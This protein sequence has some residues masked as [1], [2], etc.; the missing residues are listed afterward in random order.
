MAKEKAKSSRRPLRR[1]K[2]TKKRTD[3]LNETTRRQNKPSKRRR[4]SGEHGKPKELQQFV[5]YD[6]PVSFV[7]EKYLND[8]NASED[9][10][11]VSGDAETKERTVT[12]EGKQGTY[13]FHE[14]V[15][16]FL[17][18]LKEKIESLSAIDFEIKELLGSLDGTDQQEEEDKSPVELDVYPARPHGR[19]EKL[20]FVAPCNVEVIGRYMLQNVHALPNF[21]PGSVSKAGSSHRMLPE[22]DLSFQIPSS[23]FETRDYLNYRY[24]NRKLLYVRALQRR[25][26]HAGSKQVCMKHLRGDKYRPMLCLEERFTIEAREGSVGLPVKFNLI[27]TIS[28][29]VFPFRRFSLKQNNVRPPVNHDE[30]D[31]SGDQVLSPTP[32]YNHQL[33]E[34]VCPTNGG[35]R[36]SDDKRTGPAPCFGHFYVLRLFY[37][38]Q[39]QLTSFNQTCLLIDRFL[40]NYQLLCAEQKCLGFDSFEMKLLLAYFLTEKKLLVGNTASGFHVFVLLLSHFVSSDLSRTVLRLSPLKDA[41]SDASG[42]PTSLLL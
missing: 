20:S 26:V 18:D 25:L 10:L 4:K 31:V 16:R 19:F 37:T 15:K 12:V 3:R 38:L 27:P 17:F 1:E 9:L 14:Q 24:F 40:E 41:R 42:M 39:Q 11:V 36:E 13:S 22:I 7:M 21:L 29:S 28:L 30:E 35:V 34:D 2:A 6:T 23:I 8:L 33:M 5:A 32:Y